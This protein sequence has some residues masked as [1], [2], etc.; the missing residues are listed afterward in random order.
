MFPV[1]ASEHI[2]IQNYCGD[3]HKRKNLSCATYTGNDILW[4]PQWIAIFGYLPKTEI[5][6]EYVSP[7]PDQ[8]EAQEYCILALGFWA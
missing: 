3:I 4:I 1:A 8:S 2:W 7:K 6:L 5:S